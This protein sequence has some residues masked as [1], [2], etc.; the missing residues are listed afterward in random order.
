[1]ASIEQR[2]RRDGTTV[3]RISYRVD[4]NQRSD[5]VNTHAE[6]VR[7]R[8]AVERLGGDVARALLYAREGLTDDAAGI[9]TTATYLTRY[10]DGLENITDG[11]RRDY[12]RMAARRIDGTVIGETPVQLVTRELVVAWLADLDVSAKTRRNH[13]ALLSAALEHASRAGVRQGNPA[14]GIRFPR[15]VTR[16]GVFLNPGEVAVIAAAMPA[17]YLPLFALLVGT[18]LR[19]SEAT[20]LQVG[21]VDLDAPV[22]LLRVSRAWKRTGRGQSSEVGPPK[23]A[24]GVRTIGLSPEVVEQIR[25]MVEDRPTSA[26]L[27]TAQEGG[28]VRHDKFHSRVWKP[29]LDALNDAGTLSKRPRVHDLRHTHASQLIASGAP[30]N[31]VQ[32]RLGHEK[33]TTTADTYGHLAPDY[34]AVGALAA[35]SGLAQAFP[36]IEA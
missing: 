1:M 35:S 26:L 18:G 12:R 34:L 29:M 13:H 6:A 21:D 9:T 2:T 24:A 33:I 10:I 16:S 4:G 22:P 23:S 17:R 32:K 19:W 28:V 36:A 14:K 25:P 8:A 15:E 11:T 27:F 31:L 7:H 5:T 20:A 30:L 3:W